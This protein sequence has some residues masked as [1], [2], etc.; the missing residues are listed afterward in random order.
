M[1]VVKIYFK[2]KEYYI[3]TNKALQYAD[4]IEK[5]KPNEKSIF[6]ILKKRKL[7]DE[8]FLNTVNANKTTV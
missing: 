8:V 2:N 3:D 6:K 1:E 7:L 5:I 4:I